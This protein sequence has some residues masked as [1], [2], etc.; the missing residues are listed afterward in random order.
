MRCRI[1]LHPYQTQQSILV[2]RDGVYTC[3]EYQSIP[4]IQWALLSGRLTAEQIIHENQFN[5]K[6]Y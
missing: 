3:G 2:V 1:S 4:G 5:K 6:T